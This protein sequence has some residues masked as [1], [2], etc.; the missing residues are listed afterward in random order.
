VARGSEPMS[1]T[2]TVRIGET[3]EDFV[4]ALIDFIQGP[5]FARH[6]V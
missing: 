2:L 3:R 6:G 4:H 1:E 5:L